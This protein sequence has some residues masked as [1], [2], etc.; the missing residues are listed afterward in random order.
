MVVN[1][2]REGLPGFLVCRYLRYNR[3][4]VTCPTIRYSTGTW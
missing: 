4:R 3:P 2:V 1:I